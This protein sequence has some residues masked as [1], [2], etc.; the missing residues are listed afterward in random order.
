ME[1]VFSG[2]RAKLYFNTAL[3]QVEA[4]FATGISVNENHTLQRVNVLG[5]ID[6]EEIIPTSRS[7]DVRCDLV[8][9]SGRSL[10][11]LGI[12]P[13]GL[14]VDVLSFP[15][16]TIVVYDGVENKIVAQ[17]EGAR[18]ETRSFQVQAGA[19]VSENASFQAK[20]LKDEADLTLQ[21]LIMEEQ[22]P[23]SSISVPSEEIAQ[24]KDLM[25]VTQNN[26]PLALAIFAI[27]L[28]NKIKNNQVKSELETKINALEARIDKLN[29]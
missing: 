8:R 20:R 26:V 21:D 13:K 6:S 9:I 4:G 28:F 18:C 5:N 14:T 16:L 29:K 27:L 19:I 2:A 10:R 24:I 17:I 1:K 12:W 25:Q 15:E 23:Q 11:Q 22:A 3:G 7:V